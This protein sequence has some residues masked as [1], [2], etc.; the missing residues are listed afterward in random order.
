MK[1][2]F[3]EQDLQLIVQPKTYRTEKVIQKKNEGDRALFY[4]K[5]KDYPDKFNSSVFKDET[6]S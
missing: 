5:W 6:E 4:V 1:G 2:I 3:Y